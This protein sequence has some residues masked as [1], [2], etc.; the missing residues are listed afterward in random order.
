MDRV[1]LDNPLASQLGSITQTVEICD[2]T[3]VP[4]GVFVPAAAQRLPGEPD[5][6]YPTL[7]DELSN[8]PADPRSLEQIW[9]TLGAK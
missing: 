2:S 9:V 8:A 5:F 3:G 1:H 4:I 7:L 6:D